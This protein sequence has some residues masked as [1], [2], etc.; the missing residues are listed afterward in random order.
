MLYFYW[1]NVAF[2]ILFTLEA[3]LKIVAFTPAVSY[4]HAGLTCSWLANIPQ[5][6]YIMWN[7][8]SNVEG[9]GGK[10]L[11]RFLVSAGAIAIPEF[12]W[13]FPPKKFQAIYPSLP[14]YLEMSW[15]TI[16]SEG[17][18]LPNVLISCFIHFCIKYHQFCSAVC[19]HQLNI[20]VLSLKQS[21]RL[22]THWL[23]ILWFLIVPIIHSI[24]FGSWT[25]KL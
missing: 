3:I 10:Q 17:D 23:Y 18:F 4:Y 16:G 2:T 12:L 11:N 24:V 14:Y 13:L 15:V 6:M 22:Q 9:C 8:M 25:V 7:V 19:T 20:T 1:F 21:V 5:S